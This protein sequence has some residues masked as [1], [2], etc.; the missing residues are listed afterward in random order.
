L[1]RLVALVEILGKAT[2]IGLVKLLIVR[3]SRERKVEENVS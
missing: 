2:L 3:G 1:V